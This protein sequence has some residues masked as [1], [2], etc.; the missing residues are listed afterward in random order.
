[1][2]LSRTWKAVAVVGAVALIA[3]TP[4]VWLVGGSDPGQLAGAS[5][6]GATGIVALVWA[7][8]QRPDAGA[9]DEASDTG[10]AVAR[11]GGR[12]VAGVRRPGGRGGG[13][14]TARST[15]KATATGANGEATSGIDYS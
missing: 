13:K 7:L 2:V 5:V 9:V 1:M 6:Q 11:D 8:F 15:G 14:A 3:T 4:L 12:A 10:D